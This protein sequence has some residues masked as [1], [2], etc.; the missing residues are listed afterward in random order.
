MPDVTLKSRN[1]YGIIGETKWLLEMQ[2]IQ[3]L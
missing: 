3:G 2:S 1:Y